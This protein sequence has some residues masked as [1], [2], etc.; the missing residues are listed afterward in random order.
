MF[1]IIMLCVRFSRPRLTTRK[2]DRCYFDMLVLKTPFYTSP[3]VSEDKKRRLK[4]HNLKTMRTTFISVHDNEDNNTF[5]Q[6]VN[7]SLLGIPEV[8]VDAWQTG[9]INTI[10]ENIIIE[11]S[12]CSH[13]FIV[14]VK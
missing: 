2:L 1:D 13:I 11:Y 6:V 10:V 8:C 4:K 3:Y 12:K 14:F 5:D 9:L 7:T